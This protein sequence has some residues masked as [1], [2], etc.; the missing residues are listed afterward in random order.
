MTMKC[1][2]CMDPPTPPR[3]AGVPE[4]RE[5]M[6]LFGLRETE[7]LPSLMLALVLL[8]AL[9][10]LCLLPLSPVQ[11][12][13][14]LR[15]EV[16]RSVDITL[17]PDTFALLPKHPGR[18][19][20]PSGT[21]SVDP[22]INH[23]RDRPRELLREARE[24]PLLPLPKRQTLAK[25]WASGLPE[26]PGGNGIPRGDGGTSQEEL[27]PIYQVWWTSQSLPGVSAVVRLTVGADG[28]P[29]EAIPISGPPELYPRL[30]RI[31]MQWRFRVP[32]TL[33]STAPLYHFITFRCW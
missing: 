5:E 9:G 2:C 33:K 7:R 30:V 12:E 19:G 13:Q 26:R 27:Q 8:L 1:A 15:S 25:P 23:F 24:G 17:D 3:S 21:N 16:P 28:V 31:S 14:G 10:A 11:T 32:E 20:D 4:L 22:S 18:L 29:L 6:D